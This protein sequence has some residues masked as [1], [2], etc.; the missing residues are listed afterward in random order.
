MNGAMTPTVTAMKRIMAKRLLASLLVFAAVRSG[1]H[2]AAPYWVSERIMQL[3]EWMGCQVVKLGRVLVSD[4]GVF[5]GDDSKTACFN[6]AYRNGE[7]SVYALA[8]FLAALGTYWLLSGPL[9]K[10]RPASYRGET[11]CGG[12]GYVL[13]GLREPRCPECGSSI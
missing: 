12:C 5:Y 3:G 4:R 10:W 2:A 8:G 13:H 1:L 7:W 11:H 9:V 6:F